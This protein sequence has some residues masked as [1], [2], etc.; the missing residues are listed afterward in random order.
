[1]NS[2]EK[3]RVDIGEEINTLD[4]ELIDAINT[5]DRDAVDSL[6][7]LV[8]QRAKLENDVKRLAH[9]HLQMAT[10]MYNLEMFRDAADMLEHEM[11]F[12]EE[13]GTADQVMN[14][15]HLLSIHY[16][17]LQQRAAALATI[18]RAL[19]FIPDVEN[20]QLIAVA[21]ATKASMLRGQNPA[22]ALELDYK[23]LEMLVKLGN[24]ENEATLR[25]NIGVNYLTIG[26]YDKALEK[27]Y[28]SIELYNEVGHRHRLASS[29]HSIATVY[30]NK[31]E[32]EKAIEYIYEAIAINEDLE[33]HN[34]LGGNYINLGFFY[35]EL[36]R[37]EE[38]RESFE[39]A[40][41]L[42]MDSDIN[43]KMQL[44]RGLSNLHVSLGEYHRV[45]EYLD[46]YHVFADRLADQGHMMLV[47]DLEVTLA[48]RQGEY[49]KA[50][51]ALK[52]FREYKKAH[53]SRVRNRDIDQLR[54]GYEADLKIAENELLGIQIEQKK[55]L[56]EGRKRQLGV[57]FIMA[58]GVTVLLLLLYRSKRRVETAYIALEK[59]NTDILAKNKELEYL[60]YALKQLNK[61]KSQL[62]S[63]IVHDLRN[64][65][66]GISACIEILEEDAAKDLDELEQEYLHIAHRSMDRLKQMV[67][68][69]LEV[70]VMEKQEDVE[71]IPFSTKTL[72]QDILESFN[73]RAA[74][75][76]IKLLQ[77]LGE[78]NVEGNPE[79]L[80]RILDNLVSNAIKFSEKKSTITVES[81]RE[82]DD[83]WYIRV[84]D[85]GPGFTE[86]DKER[87][88]QLFAK[89]SAKPT[90]GEE[91]TGLGLYAVNALTKRLGGS[92][93]L[94][95]KP[96]KGSSFI[97]RFPTEKEKGTPEH[98]SETIT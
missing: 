73:S 38:A 75:K 13:Y 98:V 91:S 6:S 30:Q 50:L 89:L 47:W 54:F 45:R 63:T 60:N 26:E 94:E 5:F 62:V 55:E 27:M 78:C 65:L 9:L 59:K 88:F 18:N 66:F 34:L 7:V 52:T 41:G 22:R 72:I 97:C 19:D 82:G 39:K 4:R 37:F 64:P 76:K 49:S 74:R 24:V 71:W 80:S 53:H 81:G 69:L 11:S 23:A 25:L 56:S 10:H 58:M 14:A 1:M 77:T 48:K 68:S 85:E 12:F 84:T 44:A 31:K 43:L 87:V 2:C 92:V 90:G 42:I 21:Y 46:D 40:S 15:L 96:G 16:L 86:T 32:L 51:A 95:S 20:L 8:A 17:R 36:S 35:V 3:E 67:N 29:Y 83:V 70:H 79:F 28:Q 61:D 33:R 93:T 57:L